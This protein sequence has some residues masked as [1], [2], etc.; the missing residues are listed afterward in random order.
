MQFKVKETH[1]VASGPNIALLSDLSGLSNHA[2]SFKVRC[3]SILGEGFLAEF[4]IPK[5]VKPARA[6]DSK[7]TDLQGARCFHERFST[8]CR[9]PVQFRRIRRGAEQSCGLFC[10]V[11]KRRYE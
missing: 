9:V 4:G 11:I 10:R 5:E 1:L 2:A 3:S 6:R 7:L 8:L